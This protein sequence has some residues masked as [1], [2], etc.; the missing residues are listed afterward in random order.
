MADEAEKM[1]FAEWVGRLVLF[2]LSWADRAATAKR[3]RTREA[4]EA[5]E[6]ER[7]EQAAALQ[8][9]QDAAQ[10]AAQADER[11]RAEKE[12]EAALEDA[13]IRAE[14]TRFKCQ[15]LYD[16]HEYKIRD[17]FPQEKLK[18]Y[19]EEY[20][21]DELSIEVIE[22]RGQELEAMIH[23]FLDDGKP[24][25][26]RSRVELKA[27]FDKQRADAKEA[28]LSTEVLEATLVDINVREDQAMMDFLGDE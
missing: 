16:Q 14:R 27:F 1:S 6:A 4:A 22:R 17:K 8:R 28:G 2:P 26:P 7:R 21:D 20:L 25:K 12:Q 11:R 5:E 3:R 23:G 10:A 18:H 19:F 9:Q 13:K 24:K 15:L